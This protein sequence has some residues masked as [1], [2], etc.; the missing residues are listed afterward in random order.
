MNETNM[1][2]SKKKWLP[3]LIRGIMGVVIAITLVRQFVVPGSKASNFPIYLG[4]YFLANGFL[5]LKIARAAP[6]RDKRSLLAALASIIGG[7]ALVFTFPFSDYRDSL[8]AT[9]LGRYVFSII[10]G[11][12]GLLQLQGAVH[13]TPQPVLKRAHVISGILEIL[14]A[15]AVALDPFGKGGGT[16][17]A[18]AFIWTIFISFYM[19]LV[20]YRVR[21]TSLGPTNLG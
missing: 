8:I 19:F 13:M 17:N 1:K 7:F 10:V 9:D 11:V 2:P 21:S 16:D 4:A 12:I 18:V 5:S 14:L 6:T 3:Y 20:A 15:L